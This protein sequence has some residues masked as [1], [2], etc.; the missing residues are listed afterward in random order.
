MDNRR[1]V[2]LYV[3][4]VAVQVL[5][6]VEE[7]LGGLQGWLEIATGKLHT[8]IAGLPVLSATRGTF[9]LVNVIVVAALGSLIPFLV[10]CRRWAWRAAG[11][12]AV[13]E[14]INGLAHIVGSAIAG[15]Y[16]PGAI[17]AAGLLVV[18][19]WLI[20]EIIVKKS[21]FDRRKMVHLL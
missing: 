16:I 11:A 3:T 18:G 2:R 6:S 17:S 4:L 1:P 8:A 21:P 12:V 20:G 7:I 15:Q 9:I 5:H 10:N 13:I 14:T 19:I